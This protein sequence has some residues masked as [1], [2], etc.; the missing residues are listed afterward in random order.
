MNGF[1][2]YSLHGNE[3]ISVAGVS[4]S[5]GVHNFITPVQRKDGGINTGLA[6]HNLDDEMV[7]V[8]CDLMKGGVEL[9]SESF[10]LPANGQSAQFIDELFLDFF[11]E[12]EPE[13][14]EES[15]E[16]SGHDLFRGSVSCKASRQITSVALEYNNSTNV[17]TT[18][19][20]IPQ[21]SGAD[22]FFSQ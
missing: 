5:A 4:S 19:P 1:V 14:E 13:E 17:L 9:S 20:V 15:T 10:E 8:R 11:A 2:R 3:G 7:L 16:E 18:L 12:P 21:P 22:F 6:V